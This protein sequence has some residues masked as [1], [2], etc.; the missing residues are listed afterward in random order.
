MIFVLVQLCIRTTCSAMAKTYIVIAASTLICLR[1]IGNSI[2]VCVLALSKRLNTPTY[3]LIGYLAVS[4][5]LVSVTQC[6]CIL[7]GLI[8]HAEDNSRSIM[9]RT[10]TFLYSFSIF[11]YGFSTI[12]TFCFHSQPSA[13]F[14]SDL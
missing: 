13:Q 3:V 10:F 4:D 9:Y 6:V 14:E 2:T 11:S 7:P 8:E 12:C 5:L 1:S